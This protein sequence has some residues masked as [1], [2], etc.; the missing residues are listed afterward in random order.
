MHGHH[1]HGLDRRGRREE[2]GGEDVYTLA[3]AMLCLR[4][5]RSVFIP[6]LQRR[7][8]QRSGPTGQD[9]VR[10]LTSEYKTLS[11]PFR[12]CSCC[13]CSCCWCCSCCCASRACMA[14]GVGVSDAVVPFANQPSVSLTMS[15]LGVSAM[16]DDEA[17]EEEE[18]DEEGQGGRG[19]GGGDSDGD[20]DGDGST[21]GCAMLEL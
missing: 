1:E 7:Q 14:T 15:G 5:V 20:G 4:R 8:R 11:T 2:G 6:I 3:E 18:E 17:E 9:I 19:W 16:V 12:A 13:S 10:V 21:G